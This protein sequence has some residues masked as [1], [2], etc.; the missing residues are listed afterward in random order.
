M[1]NKGNKL[2]MATA[3]LFRYSIYFY[4]ACI[5]LTYL[6]VYLLF[7]AMWLYYSILSFYHFPFGCIK[8][9]IYT[10]GVVVWWCG[11]GVGGGGVNKE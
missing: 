9:N 11:G 1:N 5:A 10:I 8:Q 2:K 4:V 3:A 7:N 6:N